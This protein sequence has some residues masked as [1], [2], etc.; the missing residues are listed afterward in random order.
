MKNK[1]CSVYNKHFY[2]ATV[3]NLDMWSCMFPLFIV[4][5]VMLNMVIIAIIH[6]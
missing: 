4:Y 6:G 5:N 2:F 1:F 3:S